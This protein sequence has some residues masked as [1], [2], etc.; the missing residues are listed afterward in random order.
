MDDITNY[1]FK[2]NLPEEVCEC[3]VFRHRKND[4]HF[5][6]TSLDLTIRKNQGI[7]ILLSSMWSKPYVI[8]GL[9][10]FYGIK[11]IKLSFIGNSLLHHFSTNFLIR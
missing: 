10:Y 8:F 5:V 1:F 3:P 6:K 2:S 9:N 11:L 7:A 4:H